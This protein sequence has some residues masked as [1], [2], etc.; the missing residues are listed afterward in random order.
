MAGAE[1]DEAGEEEEV[2]LDQDVVDE[3]EGGPRR[4]GRGGQGDAQQ[5]IADLADDVEG[6]DAAQ[7][8]VIGRPQDA[9]D[10]GEHGQPAQG[11]VE[12]GRGRAEHLS[13]QAQH[14]I[15]GDLGQQPAHQGQERRGQGVVTGRQPGEEGK[16]AGLEQHGQQQHDNEQGQPG[17]D[18]RCLTGN[19]QG[20]EVELPRGAIDEAH[21]RQH[22]QGAQ[23]AQGE[24]LE[25]RLGLPGSAT[26]E[27]QAQG[28][29][30]QELE[31]D[32]EIEQV[33]RQED[34]HHRRQ[35]ALDQGLE[36]RR[37]PVGGLGGE[38]VKQDGQPQQGRHQH[39]R[40]TQA[41]GDE[42]DGKRQGPVAQGD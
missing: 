26:Q 31:P 22:Q 41:I 16:G 7:V 9:G 33:R 14:H 23:H 21:G 40:G 27:Q 32:I 3:E 29:H 1:P 4:P 37:L 17:R 39:Q 24:I 42:L 28:G 5:Q 6:E 12:E 15:D 34:R 13:R 19:G 20:A 10:Q 38:L 35:Q 8:P 36:P 2:G 18:P 25:G 11:L 30:E